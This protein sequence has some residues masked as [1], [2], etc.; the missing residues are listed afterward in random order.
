MVNL[1]INNQPI[2]PQ[3]LLAYKDGR[4]IGNLF[5]DEKSLNIK[6]ELEDS[7]ILTSEMSCDVY[8]LNTPFWDKITDFKLIYIPIEVPYIK[9]NGFWYEITVTIDDTDKTIKHIV[10]TLAQ[11]AEL[12][13]VYNY[14]VE[15][16]TENDINRDDYVDTIFYNPINSDASIIDR[17][18]K[19]KAPHYSVHYVED[20][21]RN[22][23]RT[24]EFNGDSVLE[25]L[26]KIAEEVG[27]IIIFGESLYNN[28]SYSRS[29]SFYEGK[30]Y[31]PVCGK[32]GDF[33]NG[34]TNPDCSHSQ[35]IIPRYGEETG[36]FI[37]KENLGEN[38]NLSTNVEEVKNYYRL[39]AGDD[40][41]TATIINC[42]PSGSRY[43]WHFT[44]T[45]KQDMSND[46]RTAINNYI[47]LYNSYKTSYE[48]LNIA[49][50]K[51]NIYNSYISSYASYMS[52]DTRLTSLS[53]PIV[54]YENL[55]RAYYYTTYL[56]DFL[57][58]L[59][60]PD[61]PVVQETTAEEQMGLFTLT[62]IGVR[63]LVTI[64]KTTA[65]NEVRDAVKIY[66]DTSRYKVSVF[67]TSFNNPTWIGNITLTSLT[68]DEDSYSI[69]KQL[70]F[71]DTTESY[72]KNQI[73][74]LLKKHETSIVGIKALLNASNSDFTSEIDKYCLSYLSIIASTITS[75]LNILDDA[76]VTQD[77]DPDVYNEI[78]TPY[79]QKY[80]ILNNKI[81]IRE[82]Q[83]DNIKSLIND[84]R[85][86]YTTINNTLK[87]EEF[88]SEELWLEL[89]SFRREGEIE[90]S[91]Y[92]SDGLNNKE[93]IDNAM[94]F[95]DT[96][97]E[98][99]EKQAELQYTITASLK[100]LLLFMTDRFSSF[101]VGDWIHIEI[102][103]DV[104]KLRMI[105][106]EI[107][108]NDLAN[109]Q[110]EFTD[111]KK[112]RDITTQFAEY[113][114]TISQ[115]KQKVENT[116]RQVTQLQSTPNIVSDNDVIIDENGQTLE[117]YLKEEWVGIA[118]AVDEASKKATNYLAVDNSGLMV[119]DMS[120]GA[121]YTPSTV[122][123]GVKNAFIDDD[124]FDIRDGQNVLASFGTVSQIGSNE[125]LRLR[126][127]NDGLYLIS[128]AG[129]PLIKLG[130]IGNIRKQKTEEIVMDVIRDYEMKTLNFP[131]TIAQETTATIIIN[132][133]TTVTLTIGT[134]YAGS[135]GD[136]SVNYDGKTKVEVELTRGL[137]DIEMSYYV[138]ELDACS[139]LLGT[140]NDSE[141][142]DQGSL[143]GDRSIM[144]GE[145][146][147]A[148][149]NNA[150]TIGAALKTGCDMQFVIGE[151]N[152]AES[153]H[154]FEIGAGESA[155]EIIDEKTI[156][157]RDEESTANAFAVGWDGNVEMKIDTSA[158]SGTVDGDLYAA[159]I[160]KN[161]E[162][163]VISNNMINM[164][165]LLTRIINAL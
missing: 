113:K 132:T 5:Y 102:D 34:C 109:I 128:A 108:Y 124:S 35:E 121:R 148:T 73:D 110:A 61:S 78:Y 144:I 136:I 95:Y 54:G 65:A 115:T 92:I 67:T 47:S 4:I 129:D 130:S 60:S 30:D 134:E 10:G 156:H 146:N 112:F 99:I 69:N 157:E 77:S 1:D 161:W 75:V 33:T 26:K 154:A 18:L 81:L 91:N 57:N 164:K 90:N 9:T 62:S 38:I 98:D 3:I 39:T 88:L 101:D 111:V 56:H 32:R 8:N 152:T 94:E 20:S 25:C 44:D 48:M 31:C 160:N 14:E 151:A 6:V 46:L 79:S 153:R 74:Q 49:Q 126:L 140:L 55:I 107:N 155:I 22:V 89:L 116:S 142:S 138:D 141:I 68:D 76:G 143:I 64:T 40:D 50:S 43:I 41:M 150:G 84:I 127:L 17:V 13:S 133:I 36:L 131:I 137:N 71:V 59:M 51:I 27:C 29:I 72:V 120:D 139:F 24:F 125:N 15:I 63:A 163:S 86:Q 114:K 82:T 122:P 105:S 149:H 23:K 52:E 28:I 12:D 53:Y 159:I 37:N 103:G 117:E 119:A 45:M 96:A 162:S 100:N 93:L 80:L 135:S 145:C 147:I 85:V 58:Y 42:N 83:V 158:S 16:R 2:A 118:I 7:L 97:R 70:N 66:V 104:Y 19:D 106:Y 87:L 123:S 165:R 11:Y 21:L